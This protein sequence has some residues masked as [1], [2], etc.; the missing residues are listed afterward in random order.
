MHLLLAEKAYKEGR[1]S[2]NLPFT[3]VAGAFA[4]EEI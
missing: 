3:T 2:V 4:Y 1:K